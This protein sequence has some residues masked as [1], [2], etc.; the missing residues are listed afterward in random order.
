MLHLCIQHI[1]SYKATTYNA[2]PWLWWCLGFCHA[3]LMTVWWRKQWRKQSSNTRQQGFHAEIRKVRQL[4]RSFSR[5]RC[6]CPLGS[7]PDLEVHSDL[8]KI[9]LNPLPSE[10]CYLCNL[11]KPGVQ[12]TEDKAQKK[13]GPLQGAIRAEISV[14]PL[15]GPEGWGGSAPP[16]PNLPGL[17]QQFATPNSPP[18]GPGGGGDVKATDISGVC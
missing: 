2:L 6:Q 14:S 3:K 1:Y 11:S 8:G 18:P 17:A 5:P 7:R 9:S 12:P 15:R 4:L 10:V 13:L 16:T